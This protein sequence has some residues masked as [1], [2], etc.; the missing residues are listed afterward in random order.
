MDGSIHQHYKDGTI[1]VHRLMV[2]IEFLTHFEMSF[3]LF[4]IRKVY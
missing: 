2:S 4:I 3:I 1:R